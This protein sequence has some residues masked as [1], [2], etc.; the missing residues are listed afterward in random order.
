MVVYSFILCGPPAD[1][2]EFASPLCNHNQR[3]RTRLLKVTL[4]HSPSGQVPL[5]HRMGHSL[6]LHAPGGEDGSRYRSLSIFM[7]LGLVL[8]LDLRHIIM[9]VMDSEHNMFM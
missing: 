5:L 7:F 2:H 1:T 4:L 9:Y 8:D 3:V 6:P